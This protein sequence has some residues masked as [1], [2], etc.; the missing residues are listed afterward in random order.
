MIS[1]IV[2]IFNSQPYLQDCLESIKNQSYKDFEVILINDGSLD[3]SEAICKSFIQENNLDI[4]YFYQENK[5]VSSARNKGLELAKGEYVTFL[6]AD[7]MILP[8]YLRSLADSVGDNQIACGG[9]IEAFFGKEE[10]KISV[11]SHG[12][13]EGTICGKIFK[14]ELIEEYGIRFD[15]AVKICE[16]A[17]FIV[18]FIDRIQDK[19][20]AFKNE[21]YIYR[22]IAESALNRRFIYNPDFTKADITELDAFDKIGKLMKSDEGIR[23]CRLRKVKAAATTLRVLEANRFCGKAYMRTLK[24]YVR[25]NCIS[26]LISHAFAKSSKVSVLLA[27]ISPKLEYWLWKKTQKL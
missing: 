17:L 10:A 14:R 11:L 19:V 26:V 1:V 5:G 2:P 3:D 7:D 18:G 13:I 4:C 21:E 22:Q 6:D 20:I 25:K 9:K 15:E 23:I 12:G 16:D 24:R 27:G 8:G